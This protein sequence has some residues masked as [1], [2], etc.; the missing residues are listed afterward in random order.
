MTTIAAAW[1]R[2][3]QWLAA[4]APKILTNLNLGANADEL[5]TAEL[6][7]GVTM[8]AE[9][10]E[11]YRIHNGMNGD[12]NL[13]SLFHGMNFLTLAQVVQEVKSASGETEGDTSLE[14]ADPG[15]QTANI[16]NPKWIPLAND[17]GACTIRIDLAPGEGGQVGQIICTDS[18]DSIAMLL[19]PGLGAFLTTFADDLEAG[20]YHLH[21]DGLKAGNEF[22]ECTPEINLTNWWKNPRWQHLRK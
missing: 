15:I 14:A 10:K 3:H 6:A 4:Q 8:P 9:W 7:M 20:K 16:F 19:A 1:D 18:D 21:P 22:L 17:W 11:L 5:S 12:E 13:G 2:I